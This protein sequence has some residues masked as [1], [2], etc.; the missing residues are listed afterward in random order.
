MNVKC[1]GKENKL[2][3]I[4]AAVAAQQCGWSCGKKKKI[5]KRRR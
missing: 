3:C 4:L 2:T 1:T 5:N